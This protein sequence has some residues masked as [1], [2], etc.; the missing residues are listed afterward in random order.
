MD[1]VHHLKT[2]ETG[3]VSFVRCWSDERFL[4]V[5]PFRGS[6]P[7]KETCW[8]SKMSC[9]ERPKI[10]DIVQNS[11]HVYWHILLPEMFIPGYDKILFCRFMLLWPTIWNLPLSLLVH[12][13]GHMRMCACI[14]MWVS[15]HVWMTDIHSHWGWH[16]EELSLFTDL[17]WIKKY[18][19]KH[20]ESTF[21]YSK[22]GTFK[23]FLKSISLLISFLYV[24]KGV[25]SGV[26][27]TQ[28]AF[29]LFFFFILE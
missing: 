20:V 27:S 9:T 18:Y 23:S 14:C 7:V 3:S 5:G 12:A 11:S 4:F 15:V 29:L 10:M 24:A 1:V 6:Y 25:T 28:L 8:I 17:F 19:E 13:C 22:Q 2:L 26:E 21:K 16:S